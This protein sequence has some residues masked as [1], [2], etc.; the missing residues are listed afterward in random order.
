MSR[1]PTMAIGTSSGSRRCDPMRPG[2]RTERRGPAHM[3]SMSSGRCGRRGEGIEDKRVELSG[4]VALEASEN[5]LAGLALGGAFGAI[6][7]GAGL[8]NQPGVGDRPQSGVGL[9]VTAA[10]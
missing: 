8:M 10:V 3:P 9:A 6:G 7:P 2:C 5:F 1:P 4:D